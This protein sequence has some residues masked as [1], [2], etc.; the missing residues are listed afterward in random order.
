[1]ANFLEKLKSGLSKTRQNLVSGVVHAVTG[2]AQFDEG[3]AEELEDTLIQAD[4]GPELAVALVE[5][6]RHNIGIGGAAT[7]DGVFASMQDFLDDRLRRV[8]GNAA[9]FGATFFGPTVKPYVL[10]IV[11][12]NGV[13][14]TTTIAKL[15]NQFR[16]QGRSVLVAA[17]DTFRAAAAEQL[18]VWAKRA[19]VDIVRTA[20]GADPAAV[21]FDSVNA[22]KARGTEVVIIDT[23]GRLHTK[24][25]LMEE[26]K[27]ITRVI[28]KVVPE[29]PHEVF[30]VLD[31]N[32]GQNGLRQ[33]EAFTQAVGIS[34]LVVTKL[35]GTAKGGILFAIQESL[36]IPVRFIGV[37]EGMED[38]QLFDP[39]QFV[40]ALFA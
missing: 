6:L 31:A 39:R 37:G 17:A 8:D 38:L 18:E 16:L 34:G 23:A 33:A 7:R 20:A 21:A 1:M 28:Q 22:A 2:R 15:A 25:N 5:R 40:E 13:G 24:S 19:R 30:M 10:M 3:V 9:Q 32:T 36:K 14:K 29:A 26:L 4:F 27:K 11:G 35:D 12:V